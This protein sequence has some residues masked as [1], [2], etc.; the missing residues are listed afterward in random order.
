MRL[1]TV[2][3]SSGSRNWITR[4]GGIGIALFAVKGM[5]WL[6]LACVGAWLGSRR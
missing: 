4:L 2:E 6:L 5:V 1:V 3:R